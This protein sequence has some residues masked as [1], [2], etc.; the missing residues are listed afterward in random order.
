[1]ILNYNSYNS[2]NNYNIKANQILQFLGVLVTSSSSL[3][4]TNHLGNRFVVFI[5]YTPSA[6]Y[7]PYIIPHRVR[8]HFNF[9]PSLTVH[10]TKPTNLFKC[11]IK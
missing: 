2:Y 10:F 4:R 8:L 5:E 7:F 1:M 3:N 6:F 9:S 11:V